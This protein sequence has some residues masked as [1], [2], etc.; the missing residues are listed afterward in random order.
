MPNIRCYDPIPATAIYKQRK[1]WPFPLSLLITATPSARPPRPPL[2][3]RPL[4]RAPQRHL[5]CA[6]SALPFRPR[7][8]G[9]DAP[10]RGGEGGYTCWKELRV[11]RRGLQRML[12]GIG[13]I[14]RLRTRGRRTLREL[15]THDLANALGMQAECHDSPPA[16]AFAS[17]ANAMTPSASNTS[18]CV[19][20]ASRPATARTARSSVASGAHASGK[21]ASTTSRRAIS[22]RSDCSSVRCQR[23]V[24]CVLSASS[25]RASREIVS[26][27]GRGTSAWL[28]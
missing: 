28:C 6:L 1:P 17:K 27:K 5:T 20:T 18:C 25:V 24:I 14:C 7:R 16:S 23:C 9:R 2:T 26:A 21:R 22:I 4:R 19:P 15:S 3:T 10:V 8:H 11:G 13:G 12:R